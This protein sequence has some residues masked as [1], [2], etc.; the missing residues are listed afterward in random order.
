MLQGQVDIPLSDLG[1]AQAEALA[2][3][4][5]RKQPDQAITSD[6]LRAR[7]TAEL[8]GNPQARDEPGQ[9][10]IAVGAWQG[11]SIPDCAIGPLLPIDARRGIR[12]SSHSGAARQIAESN[13]RRWRAF[14]DFDRSCVVSHSASSDPKTH[15]VLVRCDVQKGSTKG[16]RSTLAAMQ[17]IA[18]GTP[19][20]RKSAN[21]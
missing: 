7:D 10:E 5:T 18:N 20:R 16:T 17:I 4:I 11:R 9:C 19:I 3:V 2:P 14:R 1:R 6:L 13:S 12:Q 8:I 15:D 21:R